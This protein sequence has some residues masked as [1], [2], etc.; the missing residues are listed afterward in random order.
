MTREEF[1]AIIADVNEN[2]CSSVHDVEDACLLFIAAN[3]KP[4]V[5]ALDVDKHRWYEVTTR[6]YQV[7]DWFLGIRGVSDMSGEGMDWDD[8]FVDT[9]AFEMEEVPS[10]T[11]KRIAP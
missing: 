6:V 2:K 10:V 11:Y 8:C 4:V 3:P 5:A 9:I 7:G 1:E